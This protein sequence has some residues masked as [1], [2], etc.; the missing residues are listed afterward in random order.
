[1]TTQSEI[2]KRLLPFETVKPDIVEACTQA[3]DALYK[4]SGV[5]ATDHVERLILEQF[6]EACTI[7][8]GVRWNLT[9]R[10]ELTAEMPDGEPLDELDEAEETEL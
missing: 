3:L 2:K 5:S 10:I 9:D 6:T 4:C 8:A 1:M 7:L